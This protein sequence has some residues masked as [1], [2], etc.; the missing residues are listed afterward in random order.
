VLGG[1]PENVVQ[2]LIALVAQPTGVAQPVEASDGRP[3]ADGAVGSS[4]IGPNA[5]KPR[6]AGL[7][8]CARE[9]S[10]LHELSAHKALK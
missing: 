6:I 5:E 1:V 9:D 7:S 2:R 3:A 8:Q 4:V 10:N